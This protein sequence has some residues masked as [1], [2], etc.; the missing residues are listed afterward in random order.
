MELHEAVAMAVA[1]SGSAIVFAG[2]TVVIALL[3]LLVA[4]IPLVTALGYSSAVAVVTAVLG[5]LT[6]LP[7]VLTLVGPHI[8]SVH[9]PAYFRPSPKD[10]DGGFW[11]GWA[12][13]LANRPWWVILGV[14]ALLIPLIIPFFSLNLGQEDIGATPKST[15]ERQAYDLMSAGFGVGYNGPLLAA[16]SLGTPPKPSSEYTSQQQQAQSLQKQLEQEQKQ[17]KT[18]Q[19]QLTAQANSLNAQS[20][21]LTAQ[22]QQLEQQQGSLEAQ[23]AELERQAKADTQEQTQLQ[24]SANKLEAEQVAL[25]KQIAGAGSQARKVVSDGAKTTKQLTTV[26][27]KLTKNQ[28]EQRKVEA[29]IEHAKS[30][31]QKKKLEAQL[32]ALQKEETQLEIGR[33]S[34]R[35]RV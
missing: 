34:C 12:R 19:Q 7:A 35:E 8:E 18:Q 13:A 3:A 6:L 22:Q 25:N 1:T 17:G 2:T 28:A 27:K 4:G 33:A 32:S 9:V 21:Q 14:L 20:K 10:L 5:A 16:V 15:T 23:Q 24:A 11:G 26:V 30:P 29:Q 31:S